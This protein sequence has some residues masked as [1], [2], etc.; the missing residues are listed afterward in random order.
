M[1]DANPPQ[2]SGS[3][4]FDCNKTALKRL[5]HQRKQFE[6]RIIAFEEIRPHDVL[7]SKC[8]L[9]KSQK[10]I[11]QHATLFMTQTVRLDWTAVLP[12][13]CTEES[14]KCHKCPLHGKRHCLASTGHPLVHIGKERQQQPLMTSHKG[15]FIKWPYKRWSKVGMK[16]SSLPSFSKFMQGFDHW[17][18]YH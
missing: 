4:L 12:R 11:T 15:L 7:R 18:H 8:P 10:H 13:S 5:V 14:S 17:V 1:Q 2:C 3:L 6:Y 16:H 9:L